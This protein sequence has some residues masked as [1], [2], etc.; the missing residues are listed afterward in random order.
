MMQ[1]DL[2]GA[3]ATAGTAFVDG[4]SFAVCDEHLKLWQRTPEDISLR[5]WC[6]RVLSPRAPDGT[7]QIGK[8]VL[9]DWIDSMAVGS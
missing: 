8:T 3:T 5:A 4:E 1:C 7:R 6:R 2:C 9:C